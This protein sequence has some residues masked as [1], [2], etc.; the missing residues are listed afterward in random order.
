MNGKLLLAAL[1]L[2]SACAPK[3]TIHY[4]HE[5]PAMLDPAISEQHLQECRRIAGTYSGMDE[6][7][8]DAEVLQCMRFK[9]YFMVDAK[10]RRLGVTGNS[11]EMPADWT[12]A[13]A[14][15]DDWRRDYLQ[16][17]KDA[18]TRVELLDLSYTSWPQF[19]N[20]CLRMKGWVCQGPSCRN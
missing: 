19:T 5:Y 18:K 6:R 8:Y 7:E 9:G 13:D 4:S 3:P 15:V 17:S 1:L 10:G 11:L 12:K 2:L 14:T 20:D 16:C